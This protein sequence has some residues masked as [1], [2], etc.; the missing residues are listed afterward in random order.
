MLKDNNI[1][2]KEFTSINEEGDQLELLA[3]QLKNEAKDKEI[4]KE[5]VEQNKLIPKIQKQQLIVCDSESDSEPD[6]EE[7]KKKSKYRYPDYII[8]Y[9]DLSTELKSKSI[10]SL[11]KKNRHTSIMNI[12]SSQWVHDLEPA[13]LKQ[14]DIWIVFRGQPKK[15]LQKIY[16]DAQISIEFDEFYK[17]YKI[18]TKEKYNFFYIN[19]QDQ[20]FRYNFDKK[21]IPQGDI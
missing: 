19:T 11:L 12:L 8:V 5:L 10:A 13:E 6:E 3:N 7:V 20:E 16:D 9:D 21:L 1:E 4:E 17:L 14:I 2:V 18:A 15:K